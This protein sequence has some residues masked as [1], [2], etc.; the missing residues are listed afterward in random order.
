[1]ASASL[2]WLLSKH[3]STHVI[4]RELVD[5]FKDMTEPSQIGKNFMDEF[6]D[7]DNPISAD[8]LDSLAKRRK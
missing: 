1:M 7:L 2:I 4:Q 5:P 3:F 6:R 8:E